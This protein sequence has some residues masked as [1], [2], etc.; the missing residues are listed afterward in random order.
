[1][2]AA[3]K[4]D[5]NET[6][7]AWAEEETIGVLPGT[8]VWNPLEPNSY[9]DF[10]GEIKTVAREPITA[11]R[12]RR[13]AVVTD[14]DAK[15]EFEQDWTQNNLSDLLQGFMFADYRPK[16]ETSSAITDVDNDP[17]TFT[18]ASA[19]GSG[20]VAGDLVKSTGF[21][22]SGNNILF[23]VSAS[24]ATTVTTTTSS[25]TAEASPPTDAK[26][27]VVGFQ[28]ASG[29]VTITNGGSAYP[30]LTATAK[31][32]TQLG[33]IPGEWV[34]LGDDCSAAFNF[35]TAANNGFARVRSVTATV[36]TF[37]KT[38]TTMVTDAG[39]SKTIRIFLGRVLKNENGDTLVR[40]SYQ[41][42]RKLGR[43]DDTDTNVQTE[44][45][46]GAVA[47]ELELDIST[48]DKAVAKLKFMGTDHETYGDDTAIKTGTRATLEAE[49]AFNTSSDVSYVK[50]SV[51]STTLANPSALFQHISDL[52]ITVKNNIKGNKAV[53]TLG[54]FDM[55]AGNFDVSAKMTAYFANVDVIASVRAGTALTLDV[56]LV[57]NNSGLAIDVVQM[58]AG[59]SLLNVK[60]DEPIELPLEPD[61]SSGVEID[62]D[63]N[64]TLLLCFF[65][66]LPDS[67]DV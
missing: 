8:P 2:T 66:Y 51:P 3:R 64:H 55:S 67:A 17:D 6:E 53:G 40:R 14:L 63:L 19:Q 28:F 13:K 16:G 65:D 36:M 57:K 41:F 22:N 43:G 61:A 25:L 39:T 44:Y 15:V 59:K 31:D 7:L 34:F 58:V 60:K 11:D 45:V 24:T 38:Y 29:D 52:S 30:F 35:A 18:V 48:A 33:I 47:D 12:Q 1:M 5:S 50:L 23:L 4:I 26:L 20:F 10:G 42:E 62:A 46:I 27:T 49:D 32:L 54:S 56:M 37:D 21:T 9:S